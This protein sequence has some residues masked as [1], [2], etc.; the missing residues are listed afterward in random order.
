MLDNIKTPFLSVPSLL[1]AQCVSTGKFK[2]LAIHV[3][4]TPN[5]RPA[6]DLLIG[7]IIK[8]SKVLND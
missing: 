7:D 3:N 4:N 2:Y 5:S 8:D 1:S 6:N